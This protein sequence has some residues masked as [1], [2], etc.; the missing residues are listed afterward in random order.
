MRSADG[1]DFVSKCAGKSPPPRAQR[2]SRCHG[3]CAA[4]GHV[5][6]AGYYNDPEATEQALRGGWF[7]TGDA[8]VVHPDGYVEIRDRLKDVIIS[9]GEN[10]SSVEVESVLLRHAAV[11]EVAIVGFAH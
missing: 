6:M 11:Q 9:G 4:R 1:F 10:I 5:I 7:H 2:N 3:R 8:A